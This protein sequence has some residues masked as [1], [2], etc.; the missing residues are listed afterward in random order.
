MEWSIQQALRLYSIPSWGE[1]YF[2]INRHGHLQVNARRG[3]RHPGVDLH[4]LISELEAEGISPPVLVRFDDILQDRISRLRDAF[5]QA[6]QTEG[7]AGGFTPVY[8]VK[9]NQQRRVVETI[10]ASG[11]GVGLEAGS[12]PELMMALAAAPRGAMLICNGYKDRGYLRLALIGNRLGL[13]VHLVIEKPSEL[14]L[15]LEES[16]AL[17]IEPLLGVRVRLAS[18]G[19]GLWQNTG[20]EKSKFGLS[21]AQLLRM[22]ERLRAAGALH[23]LQL[24]HFHMGSQIPNIRDIQRGVDEGARYYAELR[25]L[26]VPV[27]VVDVGGGLGVDYEGSRTRGFCS[28]NYTL[29]EYANNV[30]QA[31]RRCCDENRLPHPEIVT[32]SGRALTAHHA[33]LVVNVAAVERVPDGEQPPP[34]EEGDPDIVR[35][36]GRNLALLQ[37]ESE[38]SLLE[39]WHDAQHALSEARSRYIHGLLTLEQWACA[40][41]LYFATCRR[42]RSLLSSSSRAHREVL[43][44]LEERLAD[45]YFCNF[46]LF[47]SLPD[48]WAIDQ[49]FP[50]VP[51]HRLDEQPRQRAVLRDITCDSDGRIDSYVQHGGAESTLPLHAP[52]PGEPYLLGLFLAGAYQEILGDRHNLFG[53]T[54]TVSV[55]LTGDG[56]HRLLDVVPAERIGEVLRHIDLQA[57]DLLESYRARVADLPDAERDRLLAELERGLEGSTYLQG[58]AVAG[59]DVPAG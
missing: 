56:G 54:A 26:G 9:V 32:E 47:Q 40:E 12:K 41:R 18:I 14:E 30:V 48:V 23:A 6:M 4:A 53:T 51:L 13:R 37:G 10:L 15:V 52:R 11:P 3:S 24:L 21:P 35:I 59:P 31:L 45:R 28:M 25:R 2:D 5:R 29:Q 8:P 7:F 55:E 46:S 34:P 27:A 58:G 57:G 36:M 16:A 43:D 50:V 17:G 1:G 42:L 22:V 19:S 44:E 39:V 49:L 38:R 33:V 20:G